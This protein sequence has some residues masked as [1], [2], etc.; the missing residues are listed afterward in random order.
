MVIGVMSLGKSFSVGD[1]VVYPAH[2]VGTIIAEENQIVAGNDVD[3]YVI[4]FVKDKMTLRVPKTRASKIGLR[5]LSSEDQIDSAIQILKT[6]A[7][8]SKGMWSKRAQEYETKINSGSII[9]IAE[10]LRDL[11]KNVDESDR[12]YSEKIIYDLAMNRLVNEYS[13]SMSL[14]RDEA[15][16]KILSILNYAR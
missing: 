15:Q 5:D 16:N 8:V 11:H 14:D 4:S 6:K 12:S 10:V 13:V 9:A 3:L 7:K 2:G 1:D